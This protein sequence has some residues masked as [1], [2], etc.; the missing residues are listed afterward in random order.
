MKNHEIV[1]LGVG[2]IGPIHEPIHIY[3][4]LARPALAAA[5]IRF[6]Q[7][8]RVY[9]NKGALQLHSGGAHSR[10]K[11]EM[12]AVFKDCLM[13]VVSVAGNHAMDWGGDALLDTIALF[14]K[15]GIQTVGGGANLREARRPAILEKNGIKVAFLAYCSILNEGF[16][17]ESNR[18]GIAPL[19]VRTYHE[20]TDY[21]AG[22]PPRVIT[23][24][25]EEDM[26]AMKQDIA[27]AKQA[28]D[29]V[30]VSLHWGI[31]F[32]PK[33]IAEYQP[34]VAQA[35]FDAGADLI[36]GHHAHVP[37]AIAVHDGKVCFHSLSNFIM[38]APAHSPE[39]AADF[40]RRYSVKLDP[41]YPHL[42]YGSD[43]KRGIVAKAVLS[44]KGVQKVS[45]LPVLID[46]KLRPE[47]LKQEDIRFADALDYV[48]WASEGFHQQ[49][50]ILDDEVVVTG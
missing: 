30:V 37:K 2:D 15:Q 4:E 29:V 41:D 28:A 31:H 23:V 32:I 47:I 13:D 36:L 35:V 44:R 39:K 34:V 5:D 10:L 16:A 19:R 21:Q 46:K 8:E 12:A 50:R 40:C 17:A 42:P 45:F 20:P 25:W 18:P 7:C 26:A 9:T 22:V 33:I 11:P 49:F 6:G 43:A 38:S 27:D 14:N 1:L 3:C 48:R 24:P